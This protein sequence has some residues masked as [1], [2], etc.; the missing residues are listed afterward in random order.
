MKSQTKLLL[1]AGILA[2]IQFILVPVFDYQTGQVE[3]LEMITGQLYRAERLLNTADQT[4]QDLEQ[5]NEQL[6]QAKA[7]FSISTKGAPVKLTLQSQLQEALKGYDV[8]VQLFDWL[9]ESALDDNQLHT[10]QLNLILQGSPV[11]LM[12]AYQQV[13]APAAYINPVEMYFS[14][15]QARNET[16]GVMRLLINITLVNLPASEATDA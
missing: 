10:Y 7:Q 11:N 6:V 3:R 16:L 14:Q 8:E 9:T 15:R 5:L 4:A 12:Q 2:L 1:L 13:I